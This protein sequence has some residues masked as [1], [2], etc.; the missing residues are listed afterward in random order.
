MPEKIK[1]RLGE[2]LVEMKLIT[3]AQLDESLSEQRKAGGLLGEILV[4]LGYAKEEDITKALITQFGFA[5][6]PL[7]NY[8]IN[9][10]A[11]KL[12]TENVARQYCLMPVDKIENALTI[13]MANPL[14]VKAIEDIEDLTK[15]S[16]RVFVSLASD[17]KRCI[18]KYYNDTPTGR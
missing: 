17:I 12:V 8:D 1:K 9:T 18:D 5:Y 6:L 14:N 13:A 3:S 2:L 7:A 16:V 4:R 15:C 11:T 10:E